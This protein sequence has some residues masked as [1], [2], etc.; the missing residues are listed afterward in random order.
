[1]KKIM[2]SA[3]AMIAFV[4]TSMANAVEVEFSDKKETAAVSLCGDIYHAT[5]IVAVANGANREQAGATAWAAYS[6][7]VDKTLL[8]PIEP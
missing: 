6:T 3:I 7:C 8:Q 2:F 5:Y 4:G 1:M